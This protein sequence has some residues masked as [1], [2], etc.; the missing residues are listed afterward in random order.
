VYMIFLNT[1]CI[2]RLS[3][4]ILKTFIWGGGGGASYSFSPVYLS[5][6]C[7]CETGPEEHKSAKH[8][9]VHELAG[10]DSTGSLENLPNTFFKKIRVTLKSV[11]AIFDVFSRYR[12]IRGEYM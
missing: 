4:T 12:S 8:V 6:F 9:T 11:R 7:F 2:H 1:G 3:R 10:G 5:S